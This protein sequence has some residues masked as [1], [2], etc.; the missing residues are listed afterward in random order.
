LSY[1]APDAAFNT[2]CQRANQVNTFSGKSQTQHKAGFWHP[3]FGGRRHRQRP[4]LRGAAIVLEALL[5]SINGRIFEDLGVWRSGSL[6]GYNGEAMRIG[7]L[8]LICLGG[9]EF[10]VSESRDTSRRSVSIHPSRFRL[11]DNLSIGLVSHLSPVGSYAIRY[12][13]KDVLLLPVT[14]E[15]VSLSLEGHVRNI[16][17]A[18]WSKN[19]R[20]LA[21]T[22]Y[23]A[24]VKLWDVATRKELSSIQA[25]TG[26]A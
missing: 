1:V 15:N 21:T 8:F 24:A 25:H 12:R 11:L 4:I 7:I 20:I 18:G 9:N 14:P 19:G 10:A 13:G 3:P 2:T 22:G 5:E 16:H 23:D 17:D 6:R 26:F